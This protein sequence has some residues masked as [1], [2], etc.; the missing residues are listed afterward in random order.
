MLKTR[1]VEISPSVCCQRDL[2]RLIPAQGS[3]PVFYLETGT[4]GYVLSETEDD[5][6]E[7]DRNR[8]LP[9]QRW[10][11]K[12]DPNSIARIVNVDSG[13][14]IVVTPGGEL[15]LLTPFTKIATVADGFHFR[16]M[17]CG[18]PVVVLN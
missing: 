5:D 10:I 15:R 13:N 18:A 6:L 4:P 17:P 9:S 2:W 7:I 12:R 3:F 16:E 8:F 14:E 11:I 1:E